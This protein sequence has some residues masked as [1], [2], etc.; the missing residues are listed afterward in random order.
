MTIKQH[1]AETIRIC[2]KEKLKTEL[3]GL[4][5]LNAAIKNKEINT[6]KEL[7]DEEVIAV[8]K[9]QIKEHE[10]SLSFLKSPETQQEEIL[11]YRTYISTLEGFLPEEMDE[12]E[13]RMIIKEELSKNNVFSKSQ[14]GLAM[15]LCKIKLAGEQIDNSKISQIIREFLI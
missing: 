3:A 15:K 8:I 11:K 7:S 2:M 10:Q 9:K 13:A 14:M 6:K 4:R 12:N 1:I 5:M